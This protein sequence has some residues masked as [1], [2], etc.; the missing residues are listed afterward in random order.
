MEDSPDGGFTWWWIHLIVYSPN[1]VLIW[2]SIH[3]MVVLLTGGV[4]T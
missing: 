4:F 1:G 2:W 3:L